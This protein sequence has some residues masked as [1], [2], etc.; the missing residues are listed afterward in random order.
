MQYCE[1]Q[2][3]S[4]G[5]NLFLPARY[6]SKGYEFSATVDKPYSLLIANLNYGWV[7]NYQ[8]YSGD[9][10]G[11]FA[12]ASIALKAEGLGFEDN[13]FFFGGILSF[14]KQHDIYKYSFGENE[15]NQ[16]NIDQNK[17]IYFGYG[18]NTGFRF[19]EDRPIWLDGQL[20]MQ[21]IQLIRGP[22]RVVNNFVFGMGSQSHKNLTGFVALRLRFQFNIHVVLFD[23]EREEQ[24]K[25]PGLL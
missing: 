16:L 20:S 23:N 5:M 13:G 22:E 25:E 14:S 18:I 1:A 8:K 11:N 19:L 17:L 24:P 10:S 4:A 9:F 6:E 2:R 15:F 21:H 7:R 12:S 3:L